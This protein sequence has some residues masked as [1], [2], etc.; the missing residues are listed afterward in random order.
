MKS[1]VDLERD[2]LAAQRCLVSMLNDLDHGYVLHP[3]DRKKDALR[4]ALEVLGQV[5]W[6]PGQ[7]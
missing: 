3:S 4:L 1:R 7:A 5:R 2:R 6:E